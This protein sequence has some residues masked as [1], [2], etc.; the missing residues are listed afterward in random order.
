MIDV[1]VKGLRE[2]QRAMLELPEQIQGRVTQ[3]ALA[4]AA[5]PIV[6]SARLRAPER[7][8]RLAKAI[9]SRRSRKSTP[10]MQIRDITVRSGKKQAQ[11]DADAYYWK[12]IEFGRAAIEAKPGRLLK[13]TA[14]D[15]STVYTRSAKAIPARP[16]LRPAFEV[17]KTT[18]LKILQQ[19][20]RKGIDR[21]VLKVRSR[22]SGR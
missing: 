6:E 4:A 22:F 15:G 1:E 14:A 3:Q 17:Q 7:T 16:F 21:A 20:L 19:R 9:Y 18:A 13:F 11:R 5:Q 8:G 12:F 2:R 10:N